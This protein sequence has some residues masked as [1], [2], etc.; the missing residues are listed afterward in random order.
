MK[1]LWF[2][3]S[4]TRPTFPRARGEGIQ[5]S[6]ALASRLRGE[7]RRAG[8]GWGESEKPTRAMAI[9]RQGFSWGSP[10]TTYRYNKANEKGERKP[11]RKALH[12]CKVGAKYFS[13]LP[14]LAMKSSAQWRHH[15]GYSNLIPLSNYDDRTQ[16]DQNAYEQ[17]PQSFPVGPGPF[18]C[19]P[20]GYI[21][22]NNRE[23]HEDGPT[24]DF[25]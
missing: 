8:A 16:N 18:T 15:L 6:T 2:C 9:A 20:T 25:P 19:E 14:D 7:G 11:S 17:M 4:S 21:A 24:D 23:A 10:T 1:N 22:G 12:Y 13:P 5:E 3:P